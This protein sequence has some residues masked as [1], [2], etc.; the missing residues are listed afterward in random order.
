MRE[1]ILVVACFLS[2]AASRTTCAK[3]PSGTIAG[4]YEILICRGR[5]SFAKQTNAI[6]KGRLV[7]F[8]NKL[9]PSDLQRFDENRFNHIHGEPIN[10]C[11]TLDHV[12]NP[13]DYAAVEKLGVTS[14]SKQGSQYHFSLFHSPDAGYEVSVK[15]TNS[16]LAGTGSFWGVGVAAPRVPITET[17]IA[18]RT[19][20][21]DLSKCTFQ[22]AEEHELR[23][24]LADP[25]REEMIAIG[26]GYEKHLL[27]DLQSSTLPRDWA[28]A[29]WVQNNEAGEAQILRACEAAP[30]DPLIRWMT[31]VRT[32]AN[33][34][35][36]V[37]NDFS[38]GF[39]FQYRELYSAALTELRGAEPRNAIWWLMTLRNGVDAQDAGATDA[40]LAGLAASEYYDDH[41]AELLKAQLEMYQHHPLPKAFFDAVARL[42]PGWRLNGVF[43]QDVAPY[44]ENGYPSADIGITNLFFMPVEAGMH[45]LFVACVQQRDRIAVRRDIC[46]RIARVLAT[47]GRRVSVREDASMLLSEINDFVDE[48]VTQARLQAWIQLQFYLIRPPNANS[49]RPFVDKDI[50]FINDWIESGDEFEAMQRSVARAGKPLRPPADFKLNEAWYANFEKARADGHTR[51]K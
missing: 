33:A 11:F 13:A 3:G 14:W 19:G 37:T 34:V 42:D 18:R 43:T 20:N 23:R 4:T 36:A 35:P 27:S 50:A 15:P 9:Q 7:L 26:S 29:G 17:V 24:L 12:G 39:T 48:D 30:T 45:E 2:I 5:C 22:T 21:A 32:H 46:N 41:A 25:A 10:G 28:M 40:A 38:Q 6:D 8:A 44:Y 49:Q 47:Q 51:D 16:G 31:V 1:L